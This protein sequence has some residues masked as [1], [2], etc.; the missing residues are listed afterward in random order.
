MQGVQHGFCP[1]SLLRDG[2]TYA[3]MTAVS[4]ANI[5]FRGRLTGENTARIYIMEAT[6]LLYDMAFSAAAR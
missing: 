3:Y 1:Y 4:L 6:T 2:A 5:M